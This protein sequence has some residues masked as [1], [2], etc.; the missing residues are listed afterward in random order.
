MCREDS[1]D[2]VLEYKELTT[3]EKEAI[4]K[5]HND[6][7]AQVEA[8]NMQKMYWDDDLALEARN[9]ARQCDLWHEPNPLRNLEQYPIGQNIFFWYG[10]PRTI[11][12][13]MWAVQFWYDEGQCYDFAT[14]TCNPMCDKNRQVTQCGHYTQLVWAES[15]RMGCS[16]VRCGG[17]G[18]E[19]RLICNYAPTGNIV[20]KNPYKQGT[21]V[22]DCPRANDGKLCDCPKVCAH[23]GN[24]DLKD[25]SCKCKEVFHGKECMERDCS[26]PEQWFCENQWNKYHCT[27][28]INAPHECPHLCGLCPK[29]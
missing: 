4:L 29:Q 6:L 17:G 23:S 24:L 14:Q 21:K 26:R 27:Y 2:A 22:S 28:F 19:H 3:S 8:T 7:R 18:Y 10:Y 13:F 15:T 20:G 16:Y 5:K 25:C 9:W 12:R 11:E 1:S